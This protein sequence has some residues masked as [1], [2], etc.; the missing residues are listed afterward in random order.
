MSI[1][2]RKHIRFSLNIPATM[3]NKHGERLET[4]LQQISVGGC[5]TDWEDTIFVGDELRLEIEL[6]NKNR[7]PLAC[8]AVYRFEDTGIGITFTDISQFEQELVSSIISDR[9]VLEGLPG[10]IDPFA[11][12]ASPKPDPT[13]VISDPRQQHEATLEQIMSGQ[14]VDAIR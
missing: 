4:L 8:K 2:Q 3:V 10:E 1:D 13:V 9:L 5:F 7:L 6:P 14:E 12:P 11:L